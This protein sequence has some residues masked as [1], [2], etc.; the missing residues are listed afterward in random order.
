[1]YKY[2]LE[3]I[4]KN[5]LMYKLRNNNNYNL[6]KYIIDIL[7][8]K[9]TLDEF[10]NKFK[11]L[12][13]IS[14]NDKIYFD[15]SNV[16]QID[17]SSYIQ[18]LKRWYYSNNRNN[19]INKMTENVEEI[20]IFKNMIQEFILQNYIHLKLDLICIIFEINS[21]LNNIYNSLNIL[22]QTYKNDYNI[23]SKIKNLEKKITINITK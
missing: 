3:D 23:L 12:I 1:M 2:I 22:S 20:F 17:K 15:D 10:K 14:L 21:L 11:N 5:N 19:T 6:K 9:K 16:V 8:L 7:S 4:N 18:S 13:D